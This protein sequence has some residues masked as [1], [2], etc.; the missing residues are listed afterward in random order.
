MPE[1]HIPTVPV[2][3]NRLLWRRLGW[4]CIPRS[5]WCPWLLHPA[6]S[7]S[8]LHEALPGTPQAKLHTNPDLVADWDMVNDTVTDQLSN[9]EDSVKGF[10]ITTKLLMLFTV[11]NL[12]GFCNIITGIGT[13]TGLQN[14]TSTLS[15]STFLRCKTWDTQLSGKGKMKRKEE[16]DH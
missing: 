8:G 15:I 9:I 7:A 11:H 13:W 10:Y 16:G 3:Q 2:P 12:I 6:V 4:R 14:F 5:A 1:S